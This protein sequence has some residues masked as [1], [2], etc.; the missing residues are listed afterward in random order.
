MN[1]D[2]RVIGI[3]TTGES[4]SDSHGTDVDSENRETP[5]HDQKPRGLSGRSQSRFEDCLSASEVSM[6]G[7][8]LARGELDEQRLEFEKS[9]HVDLLRERET[10]GTAHAEESVTKKRAD[11]DRL[12]AMLDF[13]VSSIKSGM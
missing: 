10:E 1:A 5:L 4:Y 11:T 8:E 2:R 6:C 7:S 3:A 9:R 13:V 12:K